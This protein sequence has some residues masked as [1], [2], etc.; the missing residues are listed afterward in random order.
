MTKQA[1]TY[2]RSHAQYRG[3]YIY[4]VGGMFKFKYAGQEYYL[5]SLTA[6]THKIDELKG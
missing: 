4:Y 2:I 5:H 6:A 1:V 3:V